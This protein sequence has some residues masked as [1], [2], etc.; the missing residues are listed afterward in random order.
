M[1]EP[2]H[3][4]R[5]RLVPSVVVAVLFAILSAW[6]FVDYGIQ[7]VRL[8]LAHSYV[9]IF[10]VMRESALETTD[11]SEAVGRMRGTIGYYP[12]GS[13]L[14]PDSKLDDMV[15]A[16]RAHVVRDI[17]DHLRKIAPEDL[18]DDSD[19]WLEKYP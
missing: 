18:G 16:A 7:H 17:I 11:P 5:I 15:E 3:V 10:E 13:T 9:T 14:V 4:K 1:T 8:G 12:S 6:F 19:A 2:E